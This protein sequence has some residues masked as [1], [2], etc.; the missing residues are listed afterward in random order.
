MGSA[1]LHVTPETLRAEAARPFDG[2]LRD[3]QQR[4]IADALEYTA[5]TLGRGGRRMY[6]APTGSGKG[7]LILELL[8][9]LRAAGA[10]A[11]LAV[12]SLEIIQGMMER[13]GLPFTPSTLA[14]R[15]RE[16]GIVSSTA[17]INRLASGEWE[18]PDVLIGD[19]AHGLAENATAE[20]FA[21]MCPSAVW[22]GFTATPYRTTAKGTRALRE[23][24]GEPVSLLDIP[25][26]LS[27]GFIMPA[28]FIIAPLVDD[29]G[30]PIQGGELRASAV[31]EA[32]GSELARATDLVASRW[33][34]GRRVVVACGS[35]ALARMLAEALD[36]SGVPN[37]LILQDT[38]RTAREAAYKACAGDSRAVLVQVRVLSQGFD[39]PS[40]DCLIDLQPTLSPNLWMQ[41]VGRVLRPCA[42]KPAPEVVC[43]NRNLERWAFLLEGLIPSEAIAES[44]AGFGGPTR[45]DGLS[46]TLGFEGLGRFK[47]FDVPLASGAVMTC[48]SLFA[49]VDGGRYR[50]M[51]VAAC[52]DGRVLCAS[53]MT[54]HRRYEKWA[55]C[56]PPEALEGYSTSQRRSNLSDKQ[57]AWWERSA[58]SRGLDPAAAE[59]LSAR[60]F[61]ALPVAMDCKWKYEAAQTTREARE[62]QRPAPPLPEATRGALSAFGAALDALE[63]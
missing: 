7:T 56:P 24:W 35:S 34:D 58:R 30:V 6:I 48:Y 57:R 51:F 55:P 44:Q 3:Y 60:L 43:T 33:L 53:R 25:G 41:T 47:R 8:R 61:A 18:A 39:L 59:T 21:A 22:L 40:L 27:R 11:Y 28:D 26:A 54:G 45:R 5:E 52:P 16:V 14:E 49:R 10:V 37:A 9:R 36:A 50:E 31:T 20:T 17:L 19:E 38:T 46:R 23:V 42:D 15:A 2:Y 13:L 63:D 29:D 1:P 12:P 32:Y 4:G 62:D